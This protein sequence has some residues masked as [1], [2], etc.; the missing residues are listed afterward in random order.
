MA[1]T[2]K[3]DYYEVLGVE[4][5]ASEDEVKKAYRKLALKFHPDRNPNDKTAEESFKELAEA[6]EVLSDPE[7][8]RRYDQFGHQGVQDQFGQGG[9]QWRDF[10]H[11]SEFDDIFSSFFGDAFEDLFGGRRGRGGRGRY[12]VTQGADIRIS[13]RLTLEEIASGAEKKI[14]LKRVQIPCT[15]CNGTG[16][17]PGTS[18]STCQQC[19]G[20]GQVRRMT[21]GF[22]NLVTVTTCDRCSGTGEVISDPCETCGGS[23]MVADDRTVS[24]R[25]PAGVANGTTI[26]LR[27]QGHAGRRGGPPGDLLID[28]LEQEHDMFTRRDDDIVYDLPISFSQAALGADIEVPTLDGK[29]RLK[30]PGGTQSGKVLRLRG[31]GIQHLN[32]YG[33]GDMLVRIHVWTPMNLNSD[34]RKLFERLAD[35]EKGQDGQTP[36]GGKGFFNKMRDVFR[37]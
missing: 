7:K 18:A 2:T 25:V 23:G 32:A 8:R 35:L 6:Y 37:D 27:G 1:T 20:T 36:E 22:F 14:R 16:A 5:T 33:T 15:T 24:V 11:A 10:S 13:L 34:E 26:R 12:D 9:F 29:V 31:K 3:R 28:V 17:K 19:K 4:R 30:V 21:G